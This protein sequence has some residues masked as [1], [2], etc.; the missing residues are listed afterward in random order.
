MHD[1]AVI[2][3]I[4]SR[5]LENR[6]QNH[7]WYSEFDRLEIIFKW[8]SHK[9][10]VGFIDVVHVAQTRAW[11]FEGHNCSLGYVEGG[12]LIDQLKYIQTLRNESIPP[13]YLV[14]YL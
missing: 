4:R 8:I 11:S 9:Y 14:N 13:N 1:A 6:I 5:Q 10:S 12:K 7:Y 3:G 2:V